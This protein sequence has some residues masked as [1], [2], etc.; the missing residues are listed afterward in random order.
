MKAGAILC[1]LIFVGWVGLALLQ[2]WSPL[3]DGV[4]FFKL[5]LTA[6]GLFVAVLAVT[7]VLHYLETNRRQREQGYLD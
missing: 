2:L 3:V 1:L 7:L 6:A 5:S 4:V